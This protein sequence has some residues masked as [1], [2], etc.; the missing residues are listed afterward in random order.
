VHVHARLSTLR[1]G[2]WHEY[3]GR[4]LLGGMATVLTGIIAAIFGPVVGG[5][6][7]AFPAIMPAAATLVAKHER[8]RKEQAGLSGARRGKEI[9]A[10]EASGAALG[11]IGLM[12]FAAVIWLTI[13]KLSWISFLF[14]C[15]AW[16]VVSLLMWIIRRPLRHLTP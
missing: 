12:A 6:F 8:E 13:P 15:A 14:A 9:A 10:I 11:S 3:A 7:L 4:F 2:Q 5:L 16:I 1:E